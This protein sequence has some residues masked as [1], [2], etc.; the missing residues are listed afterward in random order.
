MHAG[1]VR[2]RL[3][4]PLIGPFLGQTETD[5]RIDEPMPASAA[6]PLPD[7]A[8][9]GRQAGFWEPRRALSLN[10]ARIRSA[11]VSRMRLGF[12]ISAAVSAAVMIGFIFGHAVGAIGA[13]DA[14]MS[15]AEAVR[16]INPRFT[17]RDA[18]GDL[19]V[20][21]A[22]AAIRRREANLADLEMPRIANALGGVVTAEIGTFD[23]EGRTLELTGNVKL[24][25][26]RP[27]EITSDRAFVYLGE[28]RVV[29]ESEV[30]GNGPTGQFRA[31][32]YELI[33][34]G[35]TMTLEGNVWTRLAQ[36]NETAVPARSGTPQP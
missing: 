15:R 32:R 30:T 31:D 8:S 22:N 17:G 28:N 20:I 18:A 33:D 4:K 24:T 9:P 5:L 2:S 11:R 19:Y 1:R 13:G 23:R 36:S 29:G 6:S 14:A 7:M 12:V 35:A 27:F 34:G 3:G 10:Q 21:T 26:P 25:D 16:M